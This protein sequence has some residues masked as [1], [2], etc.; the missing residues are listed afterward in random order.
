MPYWATYIIAALLVGLLLFVFGAIIRRINGGRMRLAGQ[1]GARARQPRLGI[2]DIYDLDKQRQLVL[3]RRDNVEHL[4]LIG[5]P[6]DVV[7]ETNI[8]RAVSRMPAP[9][10]EP[11]ERAAPPQIALP[12]L[13]NAVAAAVASAPRLEPAAQPEPVRPEPP[14]FEPPRA[15]PPAPPRAAP[16]PILRPEPPAPPK[17]EPAPRPVQ[18][19]VA[20]P[21]AATPPFA[22]PPA[23]KSAPV[24]PVPPREQSAAPPSDDLARKLDEA[25]KRPFAAVKPSAAAGTMDPGMSAPAE[26]KPVEPPKPPVEMKPAP[27]PP[28]AKPAFEPPVEKPA[29]AAAP[30]AEPPAESRTEQKAEVPAVRADPDLTARPPMPDAPAAP[31]AK[32]KVEA[33]PPPAKPVQQQQPA[34]PAAPKPATEAAD[35][36]SVEAIEAEFARLLGRS[37]PPK[38]EG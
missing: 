19:P 31:A 16:G 29:F 26:A 7:V 11:A 3:L 22:P 8:V 27:R 30:K 9:A 15:D 4:L 33:E 1:G 5:G 21:P 18:P 17:T 10:P 35:P 38:S 32:P 24:P 28:E 20:P 13:E 12:D 34:A 2:V 23:A 25:L 6:N 37:G 14:R 36:F